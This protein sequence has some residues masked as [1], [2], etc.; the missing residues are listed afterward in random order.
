MS[1]VP[2][3]AAYLAGALCVHLLLSVAFARTVIADHNITRSDQEFAEAPPHLSVV[4]V[5]D[6]HARNAVDARGLGLPAANIAIGGE[7]IV[8]THYRLLDLLDRTG[9]QVDT[10]LIPAE[11]TAFVRQVRDKYHPV[12]L[13]GRKIPFLQVAREADDPRAY[14]LLWLRARVLPYADELPIW[15]SWT[16]GSRAH[17]RQ[18]LSKAGRL[19]QKSAR[20]RLQDAK[21]RYDKA[22]GDGPTDDA[23]KRLYFE[24]LIQTLQ[25]R[26][27]QVVLIRY[28][29][30]Q[31]YDRLARRARADVDRVVQPLVQ[32]GI[33]LLDFHDLFWGRP[34][35]FEDSDHLN[36]D[37]RRRFSFGL[38]RTLVEQGLVEAG[39]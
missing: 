15:V 32:D 8:K 10:V 19:S 16:K 27:I 35:L 31:A 26:G 9:K 18:K 13:W 28:P 29:V 3:A 17:F 25:Q 33:P 23:L 38:G 37:G 24:R 12:A 20:Q 7:H 34:E 11:D 22:F 30:T 6:S 5:G 14:A 36:A 2:R 39:R 1:S 21:Y 4:V